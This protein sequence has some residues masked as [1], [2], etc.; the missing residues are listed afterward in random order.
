[1]LSGG[2]YVECSGIPIQAADPVGAGDAFAAAFVHGLTQSWTARRLA[3][4]ANRIGSLVASRPGAI[5][6]WTLEEAASFSV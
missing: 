4:F 2:E 3:Q 5:P 6:D 1:M